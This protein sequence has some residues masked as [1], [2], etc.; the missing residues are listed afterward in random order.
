MTNEELAV[1]VKHG[2]REYLINLWEGVQRFTELQAKKYQRPDLVEDMMQEAFLVLQ[3]AAD[4]FDPAAGKSFIGWYIEYYAPKAFRIALYGSRSRV[5]EKDPI[6]AAVSL[7]QPLYTNGWDDRE[8]SLV[9][10]LLDPEAESYYRHIEDLD[11]WRDIGELIQAGIDR[12]ANPGTRQALQFHYEYDATLRAGSDQAGV[13]YSTWTCWYKSGLQ[14][15]RK[16][17][18]GLDRK[19]KRRAGLD[20]Y[21][22]SCGYATGRCAYERN[23][24]T[25]STEKLALKHIEMLER[26]KHMDD[27]VAMIKQ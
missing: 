27:L 7:D 21:L 20:D 5:A 13:K 4:G 19:T 11:Y 2:Q 26:I 17:L 12:I 9:D 1:K 18:L 23:G 24:F 15:L 16:Y 25:S 14:Q 10:Q 8:I 6:N 22:E 3:E